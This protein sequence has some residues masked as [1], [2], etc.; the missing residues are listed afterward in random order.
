MPYT[1]YLYYSHIPIRLLN[2]IA[3]NSDFLRLYNA[4]IALLLYAIYADI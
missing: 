4:L 3:A 1:P 2:L